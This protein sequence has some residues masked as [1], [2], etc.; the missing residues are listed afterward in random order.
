MNPLRIVSDR[1]LAAF[2]RDTTQRL[3]GS[4]V[5]TDDLLV[6]DGGSRSTRGA[7]RLGA[8]GRPTP[9]EVLQAVEAAFAPSRMDGFAITTRAN[10]DV[11]LADALN[12]AGF[13]AGMDLA[14]M[15]LDRPPAPS[16]RPVAGDV[17]LRVVRSEPDVVAF[18]AV[19]ADAFPNDGANVE[20]MFADLGS[21]TGPALAAVVA[22]V[23]GQPASAA[24]GVSHDGT[25]AVDWVGTREPFRGRGLAE[26]VTRAVSQSAFDRGDRYAALQAAPGAA[27][28]YARLGFVE[29]TRYR[30]FNTPPGS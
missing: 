16:S 12:M 23:G 3:G 4:I 27:R 14:G 20:R 10:L 26:A 7:M 18:R 21:L 15:V 24:I 2:F 25:A 30:W 11:D 6:F 29:V 5:E 22:R 28:L 19:V 1:N 9:D 8:P 17:E 13:Q